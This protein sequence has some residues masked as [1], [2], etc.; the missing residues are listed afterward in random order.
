M[1]SLFTHTSHMKI[2]TIMEISVKSS[3]DYY[4]PDDNKYIFTL[5]DS[6]KKR[7]AMHNSYALYGYNYLPSNMEV[8]STLLH[9]LFTSTTM[10]TFP[11][12][13]HVLTPI[14][15]VVIKQYF[16]HQRM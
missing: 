5:L 10:D 15:I 1:V 4:H 2:E 7:E 16:Y 12:T 14:L 3:T 8:G 11:D 13:D 6:V 9:W